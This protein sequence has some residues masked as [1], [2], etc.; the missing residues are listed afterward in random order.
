MTE[1][2]LAGC[3]SLDLADSVCFAG[4]SLAQ[5]AAVV[6]VDDKPFLLEF[7]RGR[8][9]VVLIAD[10]SFVD[11]QR[12]AQA[13]NGVFAF[14]LA[15]HYGR[16]G[17]VFDEFYHGLHHGPSTI[18]LL[19]RFPVNVVTASLLLC[20]GI[21]IL[22]RCRGF[23][24]PLAAE[25]RSRRSR[26]EHI[27][28]MGNLYRRCRR[29]RLTLR[30]LVAGTLRELSDRYGLPQGA[31]AQGVMRHLHGRGYQGADDLRQ[32]IEA[33]QQALAS[34]HD[35]SERRLMKLYDDLWT[36]ARKAL[37]ATHTRAL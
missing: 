5:A 32:A 6:Q 4:A 18:G 20:V 36:P 23:G 1:E 15:Y 10:A 35:F 17:M 28:A 29:T 13:D 30:R 19:C 22:G 31:D 2:L 24:P 11:N 3:A 33:A 14:N 37:D 16:P 21:F 25:P 27:E 26:A 12:I 9:R 34:G 7:R 8:G